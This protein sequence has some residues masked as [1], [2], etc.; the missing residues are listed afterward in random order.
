MYTSFYLTEIKIVIKIFSF[1]AK[2]KYE[3]E[4]QT[5]SFY[6][7]EDLEF[8]RIFS[9]SDSGFS[10]HVDYPPTVYLVNGTH[11]EVF[12]ANGSHGVWAVEGCC[13]SF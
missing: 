7:G 9:E 13:C 11:P 5:F 1:G 2:Y 4:S 6:E 3:E 12:S 10:L 8:G